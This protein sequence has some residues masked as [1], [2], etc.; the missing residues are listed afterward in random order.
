MH[1]I[2]VMITYIRDHDSSAQSVTLASDNIALIDW[3]KNFLESHPRSP[4][5]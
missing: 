2:L 3:L 5:A 4:K 1:A